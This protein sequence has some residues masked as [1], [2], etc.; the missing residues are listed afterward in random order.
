[1]NV[2]TRIRIRAALDA[3]LITLAA[4]LG[5]AALLWLSFAVPLNPGPR[6][7]TRLLSALVLV[8]FVL[9]LFLFVTLVWILRLDHYESRPRSHLL[10]PL[11]VTFGTITAYFGVASISALDTFY[12][13]GR[14]WTFLRD[15]GI[16][17]FAALLILALVGSRAW[18]EA[19]VLRGRGWSRRQVALLYAGGCGLTAFVIA[20]ATSL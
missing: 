18:A 5:T 11:I 10:V 13:P 14:P 17:L 9:L 7:L 4:A 1:M 3:T 12:Q 8:G 19:V 16:R 15:P 6:M 2:T 20:L